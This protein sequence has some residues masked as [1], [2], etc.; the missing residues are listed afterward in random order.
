MEIVVAVA[1]MALLTAVTLPTISQYLADQEIDTTASTLAALKSSI[2]TFR[3]TVGNSPSRLTHLT[4]AIINTDT[5]SCTG[6]GIA[7]PLV[8]YG[9]TNAGKWT[10]GAPYYPKALSVKGFPLPIGTASDTLTRTASSLTAA[11]LNITIRSVRFQDADAL[12]D[13]VDGLADGNNANRSNTTGTV[14]WGVPNS[15]DRVDV[16]YSVSIGKTC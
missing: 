9:I 6:R 14:Q 10:Q 3:A 2:S 4:R 1:I 15:T 11:F 12:N 16:T 13:L 5:T 7:T 8:Q